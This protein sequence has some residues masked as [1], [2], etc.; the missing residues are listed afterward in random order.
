MTLREAD[1]DDSSTYEKHTLFICC[2]KKKI[3]TRMSGDFDGGPSGSWFETSGLLKR[4][5]DGALHLRPDSARL[6]VP[7]SLVMGEDQAVFCDQAVCKR[8]GGRNGAL[9]KQTFTRTERDGE[10]HEM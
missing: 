9:T 4:A 7:G 5:L 3:T 2:R 10:C 6:Y 1:N 8:E